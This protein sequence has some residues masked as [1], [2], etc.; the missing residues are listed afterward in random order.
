M[1][2]SLSLSLSWTHSV[3]HLDVGFLRTRERDESGEEEEEEEEDEGE[4]TKKI[5]KKRNSN[6]QNKADI[7]CC[8]GHF[9]VAFSLPTVVVSSYPSVSLDRYSTIII[10]S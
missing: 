6:S 8:V 2:L 9:C 7:Y 1:S 3:R 4:E 10:Y 5:E